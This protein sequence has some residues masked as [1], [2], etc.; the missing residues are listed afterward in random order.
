[1]RVRIAVIALCAAAV[2]VVAACKPAGKQEP[3]RPALS[4]AFDLWAGYF[5]AAVAKGSGIYDSLG[6]NVELRRPENTKEILSDFASGRHDLIG[7]SFADVVTL[8]NSLP[9]LRVVM[10]SDES[11][12]ADAV[13]AQ[14]NIRSVR[15][16]RGKRLGVALGG[17]AEL[18]VTRVLQARGV[19]PKSV[20]FI[21]A[22]ASA[23]PALLAKDS[24]DA[25]ET[26]EPYLS[27]AVA[28]GARRLF[29]TA[30][31]PGLIVD[32]VATRT[33]VLARR[34]DEVR[35]FVA[36]WFLGLD[37]WNADSAGSRRLIAATLRI[38]ETDASSTGVK[39][40]TLAENRRRFAAGD[41]D[42]FSRVAE[43][44]SAF[45]ARAGALR[46]PFKGS[47]VL[48]NEYLP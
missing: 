30:D 29:S 6:V 33:D 3:S 8:S 47:A 21:E 17:F 12:G 28:H 22:D 10:C 14:R 43:T 45:F 27:G 31:T 38:P 24:I 7:V 36:G 41:S 4:F 13:V 46:A 15:D 26:W 9:E 16:L 20:E 37:R 23:V 48:T 11:A 35:R 32:C 34:G 18:F 1:M 39:L 42:S 25:G 2:G 5:P 19:D 44:Y 40:L